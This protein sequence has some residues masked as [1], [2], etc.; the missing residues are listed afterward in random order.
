MT[1]VRICCKDDLKIIRITAVFDTY[2]KQ[3]LLDLHQNS[4]R[5]I[6]WV[7][8]MTTQN[9]LNVSDALYIGL[10]ATVLTHLPL[11]EPSVMQI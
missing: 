10:S 2:R 9:L 1:I 5:V 3:G 6:N 11:T 4:H 8:W 7:C